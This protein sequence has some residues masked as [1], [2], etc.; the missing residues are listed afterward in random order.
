[1]GLT[2]EQSFMKKEATKDDITLLLQVLWRS[3]NRIPYDPLITRISFH[4]MA[5]TRAIGG[6]RPGVLVDLKYRDVC[7]ELVRA[8]KTN[9]KTLIGTF[10]IHQNKQETKKVRRDQKHI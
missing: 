1:M 4:G 7:M 5:F 6:F 2:L 10:R 3:A 8:P 9:R